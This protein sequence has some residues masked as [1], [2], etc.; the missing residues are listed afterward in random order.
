M[1]HSKV[2]AVIGNYRDKI[3]ALYGDRQITIIDLKQFS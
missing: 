1:F 2:I 3:K